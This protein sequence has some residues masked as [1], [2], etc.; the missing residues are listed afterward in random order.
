MRSTGWDISKESEPE[1][2]LNSGKFSLVGDEDYNEGEKGE[3]KGD[4]RGE[5]D[6]RSVWGDRLGTGWSESGVDTDSE[7][8]IK[9]RRVCCCDAVSGAKTLVSLFA[10]INLGI[11]ATGGVGFTLGLVGYWSNEEIFPSI[12]VIKRNL[13]FNFFDRC[14]RLCRAA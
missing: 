4:L 8:D 1:D 13:A 11:I 9:H 2:S 3:Q 5:W 12:M 14:F 7:D 10:V 6:L